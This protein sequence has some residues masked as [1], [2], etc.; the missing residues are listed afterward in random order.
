MLRN[1]MVEADA[2]RHPKTYVRKRNSFIAVSRHLSCFQVVNVLVSPDTK[3]RESVHTTKELLRG[4][5]GG[6]PNF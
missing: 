5:V 4:L 6:K 3:E 2:R 1:G